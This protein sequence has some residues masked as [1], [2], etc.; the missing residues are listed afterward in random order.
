MQADMML[1][2]SWM[3]AR[4]ASH[5]RAATGWPDDSG[6]REISG[7]WGLKN[8][9]AGCRR[10]GSVFG[11]R[12]PVIAKE[13]LRGEQDYLAGREGD[14]RGRSHTVLRSFERKLHVAFI[15]IVFRIAIEI[16]QAQKRKKT[17]MPVFGPV[18]REML[19]HH[20]QLQELVGFSGRQEV[21]GQKDI[22]DTALH[23]AKVMGEWK[24]GVMVLGIRNWVLGIGN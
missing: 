4:I 18:L 5:G 19:P 20:R 8:G 16:M 3:A 17:D 22:G 10:N 6:G 9:T 1:R 12:E 7:A 15:V 13:L 14:R 2:G 24:N 11:G 21:Y 23:G